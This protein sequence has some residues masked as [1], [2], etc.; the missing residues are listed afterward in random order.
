MEPL[1]TEEQLKS[2]KKDDIITLMQVMQKHQ[3]KQETETQLLK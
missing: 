1:F 2:M 3:Q